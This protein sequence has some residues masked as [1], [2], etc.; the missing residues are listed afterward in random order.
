MEEKDEAERAA[1]RK[2]QELQCHRVRRKMKATRFLT[3][4]TSSQRLDSTSLGGNGHVLHTSFFISGPNHSILAH[5]WG[6]R[7]QFLI[8]VEWHSPSKGGIWS[9]GWSNLA[10]STWDLEGL[11]YI[12]CN[13]YC[14]FRSY[15]TKLFTHRHVLKL[16]GHKN[17][18]K[19]SE[20]RKQKE[21]RIANDWYIFTEKQ[22]FVRAS[23][24]LCQM[25]Y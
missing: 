20:K 16:S 19:T 5:R 10:L 14:L 2:L 4:Q 1:C 18:S 3:S 9:T 8:I 17:K 13:Q 23:Y 11:L 22:I 12:H 7:I 21:K 15:T 6:K 25:K 24:V